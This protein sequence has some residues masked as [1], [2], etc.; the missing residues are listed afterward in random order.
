LLYWYTSTNTDVQLRQVI[1]FLVALINPSGNT[2]S[3]WYNMYIYIIC[4]FGCAHQPLWKHPSPSGIY[5]H[6]YTSPSCLY[7]YIHTYKSKWYVCIYILYTKYRT[8]TRTRSLSVALHDMGEFV[9]Y[10]PAGKATI[11]KMGAKV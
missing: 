5:I 2:K 4:I 1:K 11:V 6:V 7:I 9:R 10:H 3:K 8:R